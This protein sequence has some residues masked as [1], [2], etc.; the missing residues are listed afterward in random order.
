MTDATLR[1]DSA[2]IEHAVLDAALVCI[3]R[4]GF[5]KVTIDDI[6]QESGVSRASVY[7][8]F[9]GGRDVLFE[10]LHVRELH[11]F[12]EQVLAEGRHFTEWE[13]VPGGVR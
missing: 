5:S 2:V 8:L 10:A 4:L 6:C 7:R 1:K 13:P 12:F 9:P 3:H 11:Q